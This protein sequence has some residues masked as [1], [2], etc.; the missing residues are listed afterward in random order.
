MEN[1][2]KNFRD[3]GEFVNYFAEAKL[4]QENRLFRGGKIEP[5][6]FLSQIG[7]PRT[8]IN[9]R[10]SPD[11]ADRFPGVRFID[12]SITNSLEKYNTRLPDV[13]QWLN[14]VL[15]ALAAPDIAFPVY[16]HCASGRDRTGVAVASLLTLLGIPESIII[17]EFFLSF[18]IQEQNTAKTLIT[19]SLQGLKGNKNYFNRVDTEWLKKNY[20]DP[21]RPVIATL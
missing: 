18:T 4:M 3:V 1:G 7:N 12:Q 21:K 6:E 8:I 14:R 16:I 19:Q 15:S 17:E 11:P 10:N 9:L 2:P 5:V 20:L 13:R